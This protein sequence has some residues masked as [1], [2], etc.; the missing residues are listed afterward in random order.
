MHINAAFQSW[1]NIQGI[2]RDI[3]STVGNMDQKASSD[4]LQTLLQL[5]ETLKV[6]TLFTKK[7]DYKILLDRGVIQ[8][9]A[10]K[11]ATAP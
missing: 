5:L 6:P 9:T 2:V 4:R 8:P 11:P 3:C 7:A 10:A 1:Q